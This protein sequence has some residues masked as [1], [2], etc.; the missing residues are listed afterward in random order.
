[1]IG[2]DLWTVMQNKLNQSYRNHEA[3]GKHRNY[4]HFRW[5]D[6]LITILIVIAICAL[7]IWLGNSNSLLGTLQ[8]P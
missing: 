4:M 3:D 5:F 2:H 7:F 6:I 8:Q 1:M